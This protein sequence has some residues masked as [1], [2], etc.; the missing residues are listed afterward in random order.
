MLLL[1]SLLNYTSIQ[2][3]IAKATSQKFSTH[4]WYLSPELVS[5]ALFDGQV[6]SVTKRLMVEAMRN[7][8][9]EKD[10]DHCKR[11]TVD[12]DSFHSKSLE[13]F[14][15]PK[16]VKLF[17]MLDLPEGFLD[18][19]P[20]FWEQ[21]DD[22]KQGAKRVSSLKVVNDHA[23]RGVALIQE[24]SGLVTRDETQLQFLLQV[25]EDHRRLYPDSRKQTLSGQ[26]GQL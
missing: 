3:S 1:N 11:I 4:L 16:S 26:A 12:L 13:S 18:V 5:L 22:F 15:T 8:D 20:D 23:E 6:S 24:Y 9:Q 10:K 21:H 14:V 25:V 19:D 2:P 7:G 17:Q